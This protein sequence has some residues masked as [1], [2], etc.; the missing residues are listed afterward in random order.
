MKHDYVSEVCEIIR[1][2]LPKDF[3]PKIGLILG[4]GLGPLADEIEIIATIDYHDL[5]GFFV[6]TVPGHAGQLAFG[7]LHGTP[8]VCMKGRMH[9]YE[10]ANFEQIKLP[11]RVMR[12]LGCEA[13][14]ITNAAGILRTDITPGSVVMIRDHI[15]MTGTSVLM[16]PNDE[17]YGPR[18]VGMENA[19][20]PELRNILK[21]IAKKHHILLPEGIYVGVL[22]PAYETP[23]EI[24]M[25]EKMGGDLVG[26]STVQE[27][28]V[29]KHCGLK[30][31]ALSAVSNY[32]AGLSPNLVNHEE[33]LHF[34]K[35]AAGVMRL[36][37]LELLNNIRDLPLSPPPQTNTTA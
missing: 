20:D 35:Q 26:M 32:A 18:F 7:N 13:L 8:V 10:G 24:Q 5:P 17:A 9:L 4:S 2:K 3:T 16:G 19:Y 28:I 34:S 14:L 25:F 15:N 12:H 1:K 33:V 21:K 30:V 27:V 37:L 36:L 6:S 23:A 31:L 29:A 22:G 11:I